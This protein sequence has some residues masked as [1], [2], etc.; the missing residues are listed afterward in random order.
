[1]ECLEKTK[2]IAVVGPTASGKTRLGVSLAKKFNG[3]VISAD[4][5]QVYKGMDIATAKPTADEMKGVYH[6]LI[7]FLSAKESF[8]VASFI[9]L[10]NSAADDIVKREKLPIVVG[11]TGL[12]IDSFLSGLTFLEPA[13]DENIRNTLNEHLEKVGAEALLQELKEIDPQTA[14]TLHINDTKRIIRALEVFMTTG[15]TL[16]QQNE[17]SRLS[18]SRYNSFYIGINYK[19]RK[20]LHKRIDQRVDEMLNMGLMSEAEDYFSKH[21]SETAK[22]AIGYKELKPFFD[23]EKTLDE[24]VSSLKTATRRYAKRQITWFSRNESINW[25]YADDYST[26]QELENEVYKVA[27]RWL[28]EER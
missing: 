4:S 14:N 28:Y 13:R 24:C 11:G 19:D 27:G 8:S 3:E 26:V 20:L 21:K 12:Y 17:L 6:H 2:I 23:N 10:A 7:S 5:M 16:S 1:M 22:A 9:K 18:P 25:F 15:K